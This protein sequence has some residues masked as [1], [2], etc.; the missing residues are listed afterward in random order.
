MPKL[1]DYYI[2]SVLLLVA[3]LWGIHPAVVKIGLAHV[4]PVPYNALRLDIALA[5]AW[6][7]VAASGRYRPIDRQDLRAFLLISLVGF[8]VFQLFFTVGVQKTTAGNASLILSLI[9][10]SVAIINRLFGLEHISR[11][12]AFGIVAS[13]VGIFFIVLGSGKEVSLAGQHM[14]GAAMLL[15]AQAGYG[16]Y[17]VFSRD[18]LAKYSPYQ[19]TAV[20]TTVSAILFTL[21]SLPDFLTLSW[22]DIPADAWFSMIYSGAAG[23]CLGNY[24]FLWG[25]AKVGSAHAAVYNNF[26]P[27]FAVIAGYL[28]LGE[29][30]GL[31]QFAGAAI[32]FWGLYQTR[33]KPVV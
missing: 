20:V 13:V 23:L 30:F 21:I 22:G 3:F 17:T 8:F 28:M 7:A 27:V 18:L 33:R 14:L 10:V 5:V 25:V 11:Q 4:S 19:V 16:Y 32:I 6:P 26:C 1:S 29:E 9:P 15:T 31:L 12:V 24:L 2:E